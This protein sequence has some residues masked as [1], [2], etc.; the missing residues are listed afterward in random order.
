[1]NTFSKLKTLLLSCIAIVCMANFT[2]SQTFVPFKQRLQ[3]GGVNLKGDITFIANSIVSKSQDGTVPNDNY[4]GSE[5]NNRLNLDYI[6]VDNDPTTFSSSKAQL[7]LPGCSKVVFAGL[8]WSAVYQR[9]LW[10]DVNS[11]RDPD[12]NTIKFKLPN[13]SYQDVTGEVIFD[14]LTLPSDNE[15]VV[16]TCFKDVTGI[17]GAQDSPNGD[18]FAAN[19]KATVRGSSN[20]GSSAG[21]ILVVIYENEL[22][23]TRRVSIFD[24]FTE[25]KGGSNSVNAEV[26]YSGFKTIPTGPV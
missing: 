11:T 24:G 23:P 4:N 7:N 8:Y 25:V 2:Y 13:N 26:N 18:Y 10:N 16:Y 9:K 1:M 12:V 22:E 21:W 20:T 19:I 17:V 6:D 15:K 14:G 5:S 3:N